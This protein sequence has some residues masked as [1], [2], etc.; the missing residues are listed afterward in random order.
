MIIEN[1]KNVHNL[2]NPWEIFSYIFQVKRCNSPVHL[3]LDLESLHLIQSLY[4]FSKNVK[5]NYKCWIKC[6]SKKWWSSKQDKLMIK[7]QWQKTK[8]Y[9]FRCIGLFFQFQ[10][11][12]GPALWSHRVEWEQFGCPLTASIGLALSAANQENEFVVHISFYV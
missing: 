1:W 4:F 9:L 10:F 6:I 2:V 3:N 12:I 7:A 5:K 8:Y 11:G